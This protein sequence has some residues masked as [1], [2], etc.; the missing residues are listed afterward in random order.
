MNKIAVLYGAPAGLNPV[1]KKSECLPE[2]CTVE[3]ICCDDGIAEGALQAYDVVINAMGKYF[4]ETMAA[5]LAAYD[6]NGG[7]MV[8][9][10]P[11]ALT[12]PY[13]CRN[14]E[15]TVFPQQV[16]LIRSL[17]AV[18]FYIPLPTP[19]ESV[20]IEASEAFCRP[21]AEI[22]KQCTDVAELRSAGYNLARGSENGDPAEEP[23]L[24]RGGRITPLVSMALRNGHAAAVPVV[25]VFRPDQGCMVY[26]N[27]TSAC[28]WQ[29][30]ETATA[31]WN[32]ICALA[33]NHYALY[34][35]SEVARYIPGERSSVY[36]RAHKLCHTAETAVP[37][38]LVLFRAEGDRFDTE[39][40]MVFK[41]WE[42]SIIP[43]EDV[44]IMLPVLPEGVYRLWAAVRGGSDLWTSWYVLSDAAIQRACEAFPRMTVDPTVSTEFHTQNGKPVTAHGTTYFVQDTFRSCFFHMNP[45]QCAEDLA[46][47]QKDGFNLL[48]TGQWRNT[49]A[50]FGSD[51]SVS[52]RAIRNLQAFFFTAMQ[53]GMTTQFA[54]GTVEMNNW[55]PSKSTIHNAEVQEKC[56]R[57]FSRFFREFG[58]YTNV[59]MDIINEPS[60]SRRGAWSTGRPSGDP[61]ETVNWHRWL[62]KEYRNDISLLRGKWGSCA[63]RYTDF[64]EIELPED[65]C[66]SREY[67]RT[68]AYVL[69]APVADFFRFAAES[70]SAWNRRIRDLGH[71]LAP[72]MVV[73]MGRDE[74]IRVPTEQEEFFAGNLDTINWHQWQQN[75]I[76]FTEYMLNKVPDSICCGQ[77]LGMY[78]MEN[79]RGFK[80]LTPERIASVLE[81][82][83]LYS[84]GNWVQWQA[85]NYPYLPEVSENTLG[86][87]SA[88]GAETP[89]MA[90]SRALAKAEEKAAPFM[91]GRDTAE[92]NIIVVHPTSCHYSTDLDLAQEGTRTAID[93]LAYHL[94]QHFFVALEQTLEQYRSENGKLYIVPSAYTLWD[95]TWTLLLEL[96]EAGNTVLITGSVEQDPYYLAQNRMRAL[97]PALQTEPVYNVEQTEF[98]SVSFRRMVGYRDVMHVLDKCVDAAGANNLSVYSVGKGKIYF[99]PLPL[100]LADDKKPA[101]MLYRHVLK[102]TGTANG[103]F[104]LLQGAENTA[105]LVRMQRMKDALVYTV[106]N[107]GAETA[108]SIQDSE[109]GRVFDCTL[110]AGRGVKVWLSGTG[111]L[112]GTYA[113]G[114]SAV[115]FK[116]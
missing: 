67:N 53:Y 40:W 52:D 87:C 113:G 92:S 17:G 32:F 105:V 48:R 84:F 31:F 109:T 46:V 2:Q 24:F 89:G 38:K 91:G 94:K 111:E 36:L 114:K 93:V 68:C 101:E 44:H 79:H 10:A 88:D 116:A 37:V 63:A 82:K 55:D 97:D 21:F 30:P 104:K 1:L 54:L 51:G 23:P 49:L 75:G 59:Q 115:T 56:L 19:T 16:D 12:V 47:L 33:E 39:S 95:K 41:E 102:E 103:S 57:V 5:E 45:S 15:I 4:E 58:A 83:L 112:I 22:L 43:E 90:M 66:F 107:E 96:A 14:G 77:E 7:T 69:R 42:E 3:Y 25:K 110:A 98:G 11:D 71:A 100:E 64:D 65:D 86:I 81:R 70:Y 106:V 61:A 108:V 9:L 74:L 80:R 78:Q 13:I 85:M 62:R 28:F 99:Y 27:F 60:Y 73:L 26:F 6:H 34:L 76:V 29:H 50:F 72:D 18:D 20:E 8:H 35:E